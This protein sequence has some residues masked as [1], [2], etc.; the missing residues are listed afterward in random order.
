[1]RS[2]LR[3]LAAGLGVVALT[4]A[5]EYP[6]LAFPAGK[7]LTLIVDPAT[8]RQKSDQATARVH[9]IVRLKEPS[10]AI[11]ICQV[12]SQDGAKMTFS[13][14][15]FAKG[16]VEG[17]GDGIV[18]WKAVLRETRLRVTAY[19]ID[20]PDPRLSFTVTLIPNME[21]TP[22]NVGLDPVGN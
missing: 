19:N 11:F 17:T 21:P 7:P 15:I 3:I 20:A 5:S 12:R 22:D 10:P 18:H 9:A 6:A 16:E 14:I 4:L 2:G 8:V 1:M 13:T